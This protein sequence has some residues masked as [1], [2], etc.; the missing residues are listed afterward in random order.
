MVYSPGVGIETRRRMRPKLT[1]SPA[2]GTSPEKAASR[3][4]TYF[5]SSYPPV[6]SISASAR[7]QNSSLGQLSGNTMGRAGSKMPGSGSNG[8]MKL[9]AAPREVALERHSSS[10]RPLWSSYQRG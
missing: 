7:S 8:H 3:P 9:P 2:T 6:P 5:S 4:A 10:F 1:W